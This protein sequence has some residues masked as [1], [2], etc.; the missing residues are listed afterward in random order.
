VGPFE[1][2]AAAEPGNTT[3]ATAFGIALAESQQFERSTEVLTRATAMPGYQD[4]NGY[5][6]LGQA[7]VN[8]KRY[9]DAVPALEKATSL[10]PKNAQAWATLGWAYFGLKDAENF[11]A[12]AGKARAL[13]YKEPT[14]LQYLQRIEAG[15]A[16]K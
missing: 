8:L 3:Y 4:A 16:I 15:E 12:A 13:G 10:A 2:A 1:K 14:L 9:K 5:A 11:K 7:Y 6:A